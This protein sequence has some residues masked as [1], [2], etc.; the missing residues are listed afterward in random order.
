MEIMYVFIYI[1]NK[2]KNITSITY[3]KLYFMYIYFF[4]HIPWGRKRI[5]LGL[6]FI[7]IKS[8]QVKEPIYSF[9]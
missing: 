9:I 5:S 1:E 2:Y 8:K 7:K 4:I 3:K 6:L